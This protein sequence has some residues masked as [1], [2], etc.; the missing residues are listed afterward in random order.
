MNQFLE[1]E[2]LDE[3]PSLTALQMEAKSAMILIDP[4]P[5]TKRKKSPALVIGPP[6]M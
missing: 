1:D 6:K 5:V 3:G 2:P 4:A